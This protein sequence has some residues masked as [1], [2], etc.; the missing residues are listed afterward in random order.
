VTG[1]LVPDAD[2]EDVRVLASVSTS[3]LVMVDYAENR[4]GQIRAVFKALAQG[5]SGVAVKV[6]LLARAAEAWWQEFASTRNHVVRDI[7]EATEV[8]MLSALDPAPTEQETAYRTAVSALASA[9][10]A[11]PHLSH[12][13]WPAIAAS[14]SNTSRPAPPAASTVLAVQMTALTDLLDSVSGTDETG[15]AVARSDRAWDL[16]DRVLDH[17]RDYWKL[18]AATQRL[19]ESYL[20]TLNDLVIATVVLGPSTVDGLDSVVA[21]VPGVE[22]LPAGQRNAMRRWLT[23]VYP[24]GRDGVFDGPMPDR[25]AERLVGRSI[26]NR[27]RPC[28]VESLA[29]RVNNDEGLRLLTVCVRAAAHTALGTQVGERVTQWC[30]QH[31]GTLVFAAVEVATQVEAPAPLLRAIE[32]IAKDPVTDTALLERVL[33]AFPERSQV[34]TEATVWVGQVLVGRFRQELVDDPGLDGSRL[35]SSLNNLSIR[36]GELGRREE[37][38]AAAAEAVEIRR[39]LAGLRPEVHRREL[40]QSMQVQ[41]WL[42]GRPTNPSA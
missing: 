6:L 26:E 14:L 4:I 21:R 7:A 19:P 39:R 37:G 32:Q 8:W 24:P 20:N 28:V 25:L 13:P 22:D 35:A 31:A 27:A 42:S 10:S 33:D 30:V 36:L 16:E 18:T 41:A 17:E 40:D 11:M 29:A 15:A 2:A 1:W 34:L 23:T 9:L 12:H 38:L 3:T 5:V